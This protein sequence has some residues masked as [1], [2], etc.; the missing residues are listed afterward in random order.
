MN[1][2]GVFNEETQLVDALHEL[3]EQK[4]SI[5][6]VYTPYP[7]HHVFELLERKTSFT[8]WAFAYGFM[9][10]VLVLSFL[11]YTS[12]IDWPLNF[13]GK[14]SSAF[15]SFIVITIILTI[16]SITIL[17]LFTFSVMAVLYP[18]K[19]AV[20][21]DE[22]ATDDKFVVVL[23]GQGQEAETARLGDILRTHGA[24]EVYEK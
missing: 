9:A 14:P 8:W 15:P 16:F 6:E 11:Y 13:G 10:V 5:D 22:R 19:K 2:I 17:S 7:V 21:P 4:V 3:K 1:I 20:M 18:G 23:R 24:A 12:V